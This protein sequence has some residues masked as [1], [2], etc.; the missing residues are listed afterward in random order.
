MIKAC[1]FNLEGVIIDT[2]RIFYEALEELA[3]KWEVNPIDR[4]SESDVIYGES[5]KK[6]L[7]ELI[8]R[9]G[10]IIDDA[11]RSGIMEA[12][13]AEIASHIADITPDDLEDDVFVFIKELKN[14]GLNL[15]IVS[16]YPNTRKVLNRL[17]ITHLFHSIVEIEGGGFSSVSTRAYLMVAKELGMSPDE[18]IVFEHTKDGASAA[19]DANF[20]VVGVGRADDLQ[21]ESDL[22]IPDFDS[23]RFRKIISALGTD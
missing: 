21:D 8:S 13:D 16:A 4:S 11:Q 7:Q 2:Q 19:G 5:R 12:I 10:K 6:A 22:V 20:F 1:I 14:K 15:G 9:S 17:Q 3:K 23:L 18:T